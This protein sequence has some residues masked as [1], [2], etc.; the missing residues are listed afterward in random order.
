MSR[1]LLQRYAGK[2]VVVRCLA[3]HYIG[4]LV[5]Y[6]ASHLALGQCSWLAYSGE[7]WS[8]FLADGPRSSSEIEPFHADDVVLVPRCT[9]QDIST[10]RHPLPAE[11]L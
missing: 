10:W 3:Y 9:V 2:P 8:T 7:R 1:D 4:V 11:A 5:E 6:D